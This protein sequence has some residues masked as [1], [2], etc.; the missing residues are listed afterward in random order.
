[1]N[2]QPDVHRPTREISAVI[3]M[4]NITFD[5]IFNYTPASDYHLCNIIMRKQCMLKSQLY[6]N[7]LVPLSSLCWSS[8]VYIYICVSASPL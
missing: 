2:D 1:M 5:K 6:M 8:G 4:A 7:I 3:P